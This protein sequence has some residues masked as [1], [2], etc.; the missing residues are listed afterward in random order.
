MYPD[1]DLDAARKRVT[2]LA[3][4]PILFQMSVRSNVAY[5]LKLRGT[6]RAKRLKAADGALESVGLLKLADRR[7]HQ[8]SAGEKQRIAMARALCLKP[9]VLILD[10][11]TAN[12]DRDNIGVIEELIRSLQD[13]GGA[14][15][16]IASH[17]YRQVGRLCD[18]FLALEA[19]ELA[20]PPFENVFQGTVEERDGAFFFAGKGG[21]EIQLVARRTGKVKIAVQPNEIILSKTQL[22]SSMRNSFQGTI[23]SIDDHPDG[24]VRVTV[25]AG[26]PFA[27]AITKHSL[28]EM[29]LSVGDE[30]FISFKSTGVIVF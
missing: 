11:P 25:D 13:N 10:E 24:G 21:I 22:D 1:G 28:N 14:S 6:E 27:A 9:D 8:L 30:V 3:Q 23:R 15:T 5:G 20:P 17:D 7:P 18:R 2:Y 12:V 4:N 29:A 26:L 16:I 19:G